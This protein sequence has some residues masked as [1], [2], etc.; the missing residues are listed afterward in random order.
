MLPREHS[1]Q[2]GS[3]NSLH[4]LFSS[5]KPR[6]ALQRKPKHRSSVWRSLK[7]LNRQGTKW[8]TSMKSS[9]QLTPGV[10]T[11]F[12]DVH[13]HFQG[14]N[15]E[16]R[17]WWSCEYFTRLVWSGTGNRRQDRETLPLSSAHP[18]SKG[19]LLTVTDR[20]S[21]LIPSSLCS[22]HS[23]SQCMNGTF[24]L[25]PVELLPLTSKTHVH[26]KKKRKAKKKKALLLSPTKSFPLEW[27]EKERKGRPRI[28]ALR[29][30]T[31][32]FLLYTL[33]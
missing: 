5:Q 32:G 25:T 15:S 23:Y 12:R 20:F 22:L 9:K 27:K 11:V 26:L 30:I 17:C 33:Q 14:Q 4:C 7:R 13:G 8:P 21:L 19:T 6:R 18:R 28:T 24:S 31:S 3:H 1:K 2:A 10:A 29:K 16:C